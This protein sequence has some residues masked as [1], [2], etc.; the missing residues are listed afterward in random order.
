MEWST[1]FGIALFFIIPLLL[2]F[3]GIAFVRRASV[4]DKP[5]VFIAGNDN[6]LSLSRLQAFL[7]TLVIFGSFFTAMAIHKNFNSVSQTQKKDDIDAANKAKEQLPIVQDV[8]KK[9]EVEQ[10]TDGNELEKSKKNLDDAQAKVEA[11]TKKIPAINSTDAE[12]K[13]VADEIAPAK[14]AFDEAQ[15]DLDN[16]TTSLTNAKQAVEKAKVKVE[17]VKDVISKGSSYDWIEIPAALLA[18]AGIA[19][20]SGVFSS[21]ISAVNSEEK[22][23]CVTSVT[24]LSKESFNDKTDYPDSAET[25]SDNL[26]KI[27]GKDMGT[28]GKVRLGRGK[29]SV[30]LPILYWKSDGTTIVVD[31]PQMNTFC[32]TL[33]VDTP[34]GKLCYELYDSAATAETQAQDR[35]NEISQVKQLKGINLTDADKKLAKITADATSLP[36]DIEAAHVEQTK[37]SSAVETKTNLVVAANNILA[38]AKNLLP[39]N[40]QR[41]TLGTPV[42]F[43]EFSD[44]FRDDKNP[45]NMDLM[46]FQMFGWTIIAIF[47]YSWLFLSNLGNNIASLPLVP[48]SIVILTGLSQA[49]YLAGKGVSSIEPSKGVPNTQG[50]GK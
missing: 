37:A 42:Y 25:A 8:L 15:K 49:G 21:L 36:K 22:T 32:H 7:W 23:A 47:I 12:K 10:E 24:Y 1:K 40:V 27:N 11:L 50:S 3:V 34:N 45:S 35:L 4:L 13:A 38:N 41:L 26:L 17:D 28:T 30:F 6:R 31:V 14:K 33:V 5:F 9:A 19:V 29:S 48:Q 16:K 20:G 39:G 2:W 18:L 46:K 43:Y 44:L